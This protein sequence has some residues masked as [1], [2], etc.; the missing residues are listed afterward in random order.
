MAPLLNKEQMNYPRC[1]AAGVV[2]FRLGLIM[3]CKHHN[4]GFFSLRLP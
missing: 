2:H 1:S 3:L 4:P